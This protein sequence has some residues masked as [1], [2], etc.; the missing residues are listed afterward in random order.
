[1]NEPISDSF[2]SELVRLATQRLSNEARWLDEMIAALIRAGVPIEKIR[3]EYHRG[4]VNE[5]GVAID[6]AVVRVEP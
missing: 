2:R 3:L 1:M 6:K 4:S 5:D